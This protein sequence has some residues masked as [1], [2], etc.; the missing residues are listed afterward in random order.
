[1]LNSANLYTLNMYISCQSLII[2]Q[3]YHKKVSILLNDM[4]S[5]K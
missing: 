3:E 1:M 4:D 2:I 5:I